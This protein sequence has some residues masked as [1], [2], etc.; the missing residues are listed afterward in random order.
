MSS[1]LRYA[2]RIAMR[3]KKQ[4]RLLWLADELPN[5]PQYP[6]FSN[7]CFKTLAVE[8]YGCLFGFRFP[9]AV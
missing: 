7:Y 3:A 5:D 9:F 6:D 8:Q 2:A 4:V 1:R